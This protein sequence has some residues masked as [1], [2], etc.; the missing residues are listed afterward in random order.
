MEIHQ[1][2]QQDLICVIKH[3]SFAIELPELS[4][5]R[6]ESRWQAPN[7]AKVVEYMGDRAMYGCVAIILLRRFSNPDRGLF[8]AI[9]SAVTSNVTFYHLMIKAGASRQSRYTKGVANLFESHIGAY[10]MEKGFDAL[11][12]WVLK[13]FMPLITACEEARRRFY[14]TPLLKRPAEDYEGQR[15]AK[16]SKNSASSSSSVFM[17]SGSTQESMTMGYFEDRR[18]HDQIASEFHHNE[19]DIITNNHLHPY[20]P[21][22][23]ASLSLKQPSSST[24]ALVSVFNASRQELSSSF[25]SYQPHGFL[26][27]EKSQQPTP[28]AAPVSFNTTTGALPPSTTTST[29]TGTYNNPIVID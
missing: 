24:H 25:V 19:N 10:H 17:P 7:R 22:S 5:P 14:G 28:H 18:R 29:E 2:L 13:S 8:A 12:G 16:R 15:E 11:Y 4:S 23:A 1:F 26:R 3:R 21:Q 27:P 6:S 9:S 20:H